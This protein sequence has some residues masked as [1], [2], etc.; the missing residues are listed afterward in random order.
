MES[1][2]R[3]S[4]THSRGTCV[5]CCLKLNRHNLKAHTQNVHSGNPVKKKVFAGCLPLLVGCLL[6]YFV[7]YY[8]LDSN[9]NFYAASN[10]LLAVYHFL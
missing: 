3:S 9:Y 6:V 1:K 4:V 10:Y 8:F 5:Y 7:Y 2:I